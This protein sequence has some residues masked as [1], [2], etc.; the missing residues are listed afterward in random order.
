[1][2]KARPFDAEENFKIREVAANLREHKMVQGTRAVVPKLFQ[3][4][5]PLVP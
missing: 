1:M 5:A 2:Y 4:T 3:A